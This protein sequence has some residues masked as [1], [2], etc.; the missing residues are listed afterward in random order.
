MKFVL[1]TIGII[2]ALM[3]QQAL[4]AAHMASIKQGQEVYA[5][6]CASCHR[7]EDPKLGDKAAWKP[8][9]EQGSEVLVASVIKGKGKMPAH[10]GKPRLPHSDI[11]AAVSYMMSQAR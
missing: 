5:K 1:P 2:S 10:G 4:A 3:T 8:L 11:E 9:I 7:K 6:N